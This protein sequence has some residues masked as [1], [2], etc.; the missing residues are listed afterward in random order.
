MIGGAATALAGAAAASS[1]PLLSSGPVVAVRFDEG[2]LWALDQTELP[3]RE[4]ELM[5]RT[6]AEVAEAIRGLAIRGAPLIGVAA[7]YGVALELA[8]DPTP[9][10]L[11]RAC[12]CLLQSRPTAVNL[13]W[14]VQRVRE[15]ALA[16]PRDEIAA[17]ALAQAH[18]I[19]AHEIAASDGLAAHGAALLPQVKRVLTHCNTGALAA[20]GRG[21]GLAV[22]AELAARGQLEGVIATESRPLLQ[23]AR[24]TVYELAKLGIPHELIVDSAAAGLIARGA[25]DAVIVGCDRVAANGDVANKVGT[26]ALAL[27]AQA[28]RIEFVVVGPTSTIDPSC[29]AGDQIA[30]EERPQDEVRSVRGAEL[31]LTG[32]A[33]RNPAFDITPAGLITA[34]VTERGVARPVRAQTIAALLH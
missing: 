19:H 34:L 17:V 27:A 24:L 10:G 14:A 29:R 15:A 21:T 7:G 3:W 31:T 2:A 11:E 13:A 18:A 6:A 28:A 22:I 20:P 26:Y 33:C 16:A 8:L 30:I 23:G 32:T 5:L 4:H 1:T 25:V 9:E 12:A